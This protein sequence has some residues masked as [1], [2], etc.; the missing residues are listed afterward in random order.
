MS[1]KRQWKAGDRFKLSCHFT[2]R[3]YNVRVSTGGTILEDQKPRK[4]N[5]L[6]TLDEIDGDRNVTISV[7]IRKLVPEEIYCIKGTWNITKGTGTCPENCRYGAWEIDAD[8]A[9]ICGAECLNCGGTLYMVEGRRYY[10]ED[11]GFDCCEDDDAGDDEE[12][13]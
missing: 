7:P 1:T 3:D 6:A 4:K 5:I 12:D 9:R 2:N 11:C 8:D 10:C 13:D